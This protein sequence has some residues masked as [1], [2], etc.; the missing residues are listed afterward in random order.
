MVT[1]IRAESRKASQLYKS[2]MLL[3]RDASFSPAFPLQSGS[4]FNSPKQLQTANVEALFPF[5]RRHFF[6]NREGD[7]L[8]SLDGHVCSRPPCARNP[9]PMAAISLVIG[10]RLAGKR[11]PRSS[12]HRPGRLLTLSNT[13]QT[14]ILA[15]NTASPAA[16]LRF[17]LLLVNYLVVRFLYRHE[18]LTGVVRASVHSD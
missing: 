3:K 15:M 1:V 4:V 17:E 14:A 11:E 18:N 2:R 16:S 12:T 13:V 9:A 8:Q 10:L 7:A 5:T 6:L